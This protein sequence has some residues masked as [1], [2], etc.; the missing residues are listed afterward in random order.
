M[1]GQPIDDPDEGLAAVMRTLAVSARQ[2]NLAR[3]AV[4]EN[5]LRSLGSGPLGAEVREAAVQAAHQVAGSAGTFGRQRS[6]ELAS[7]LEQWFRTTPDQ[8][9]PGSLD[10]VRQQVAAL[11]SD[12]DRDSD[13]DHLNER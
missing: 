2:A 13:E 6:S 7:S 5:A 11:R 4:L 10:E 3:T 1:P 12:L 8:P 9:D